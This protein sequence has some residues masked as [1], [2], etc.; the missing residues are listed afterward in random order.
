MHCDQQFDTRAKLITH[1]KRVHLDNEQIACA[2][3]GMPA[4]VTQ[5]GLRRHKM[6]RH[7]ADRPSFPCGGCD[8]VFTRKDYVQPHMA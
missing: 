6:Q 5:C 2:E 3:C 4:G 7:N 1:V 8:K